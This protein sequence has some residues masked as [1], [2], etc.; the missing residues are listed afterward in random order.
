VYSQD[1]TKLASVFSG[2]NI[3]SDDIKLNTL[4]FNETV[5]TQSGCYVKDPVTSFF[6][7]LIGNDVECTS[8]SNT[9]TS[10]N[11]PQTTTDSLST[12]TAPASTNSSNPAQNLNNNNSN[13]GT[14]L[15]EIFIGV[16]VGIFAS[17]VIMGAIL[18]IIPGTRH[19]IFPTQKIREDI[20]KRL[21]D[22]QM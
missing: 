5:G 11:N 21:N 6:S 14:S 13:T 18:V 19:A 10:N 1:Q 22:S 7:L 9:A 12:T 20:K 4:T 3:S 8:S 2:T 15:T 16:G 17:I